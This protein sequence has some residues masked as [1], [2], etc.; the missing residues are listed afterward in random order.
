MLLS[1]FIPPS[2]FLAVSMYPDVH[3]ST[4]YNSQDMEATWM[5]IDR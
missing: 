1:Q 2:P 5:S 4:I 3:C